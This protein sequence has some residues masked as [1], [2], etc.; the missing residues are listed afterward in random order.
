MTARIAAH[1]AALYRH[2]IK[3]FT[4]EPLEA[5][6]LE[7]GGWFPGD[8]MWA[9]E[10]GVSGFDPAVP[11][12][13]PKQK[14]TVLMRQAILARVRTRWDEA[15]NVLHA[16]IDGET[17]AVRMDDA[18]DR[19][20]FCERLAAFLGEEARGPLR[21]IDAGP[22]HRFMDSMRGRVSVLNLASVRDLE[23][24]LGRP[25]D[26]LRFRANVW[27]EGWA[28]WVENGWGRPDAETAGPV[29]G[30]GAVTL[31][32]DKPIVRC[33]ATEVDPATGM[34]DM[35]V[36]K[37]L[38]DLYGHVLTGLYCSIETGGRIAVGDPVISPA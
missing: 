16:G 7:A 23:Q 11:A 38:H 4:P 15:A 20:E 1:V 27:V 18:G 3:G 10:N 5:V 14:F 19:A 34:R 22:R 28:P 29:L 30:L 8:R 36:V 13:L 9:V 24:R 25:V 17:L 6:V 2:P 37:S 33:A 35:A 26:P 12:H 21:L 32:G 31:H